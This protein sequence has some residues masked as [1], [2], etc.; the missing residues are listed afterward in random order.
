M[1]ANDSGSE[2]YERKFRLPADQAVEAECLIRINNAAF[3]EIYQPRYV[4]N[5]TEESNNLF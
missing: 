3:H 2:R 5:S 1:T 4:N